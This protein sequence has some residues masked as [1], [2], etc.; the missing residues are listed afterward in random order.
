MTDTDAANQAA[1]RGFRLCQH[2]QGFSSRAGP[3]WERQG[4]DA[5]VRGL[6]IGAEHLNPEGVVHGGVLT[7]FADYV[8]YRAIGDVIGHDIRFATISLTCNFLAAAKH[9]DWLA[10]RGTVTRRTR[11]VIFAAGEIATDD[12]PVLTAQGLWKVIGA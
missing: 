3:Y 7:A 4:D 2:Q 5:M 1:A 10:G 8:L 6:M 11:S 12:R 9:G